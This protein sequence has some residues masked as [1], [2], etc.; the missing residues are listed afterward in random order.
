MTH[1]SASCKTVIKELVTTGKT[2]YISSYPTLSVENVEHA[3]LLNFLI[4][5][6]MR[7]YPNLNCPFCD[8]D[9]IKERLTLTEEWEWLHQ[10]EGYLGL[11]G[12][13]DGFVS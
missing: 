4:W 10:R 11:S 1:I 13:M 6:P 12:H 5:D 2:G 8:A 7:Q 3:L 9:K